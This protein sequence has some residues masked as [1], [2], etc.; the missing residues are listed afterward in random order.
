MNFLEQCAYELRFAPLRGDAV[1]VAFPCD[2][3]GRVQLDALSEQ[4]RADY[5][6]AR[7]VVGCRYARPVVKA[8]IG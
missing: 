8:C 4:A 7:A 2:D 3:K 1:S 6:F 5:L